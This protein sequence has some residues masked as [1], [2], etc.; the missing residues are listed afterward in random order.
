MDLKK[1]NWYKWFEVF[2]L[3]IYVQGVEHVFIVGVAGAVPHYTDYDQH[4]RLGDV[5][6]SAPQKQGQRFGK[7]QQIKSHQFNGSIVINKNCFQVHLSV[8]WKPEGKIEWRVTIRD[9]IL[10]S[11]GS[12][13]TRYCTNASRQGR[14]NLV[15][16]TQI[17]RRFDA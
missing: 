5:V 4:V 7:E 9:S 17:W 12:W 16:L 11:S 10:V 14:C 15:H 6:L 3:S 13:I 2:L 1:L 8:L